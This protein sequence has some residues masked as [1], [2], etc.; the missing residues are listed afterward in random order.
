MTADKVTTFELSRMLYDDEDTQISHLKPPDIHECK[1][2]NNH[3]LSHEKC[4]KNELI[5]RVF[6]VK[7]QYIQ[8]KSVPAINKRS[9]F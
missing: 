8:H 4:P 3:L 2:E 9:D 7:I 5:W 1:R 6:P